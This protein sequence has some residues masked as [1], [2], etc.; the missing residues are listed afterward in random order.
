[1]SFNK[2]TWADGDI[3]DA[4]NMNRIETAI[5]ELSRGDTDATD[6]DCD[7]LFDDFLQDEEQDEE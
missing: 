2:R 6:S 3:L 4:N 7:A 5:D 1:M